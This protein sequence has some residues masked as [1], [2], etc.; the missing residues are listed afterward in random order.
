[1]NELKK[2]LD[3]KNVLGEFISIKPYVLM[4]L[5]VFWFYIYLL[6]NLLI[7]SNFYLLL[8]ILMTSFIYLILIIFT[9]I[10][11]YLDKDLG[12]SDKNKIKTILYNPLFLISYVYC[13]L[14]AA[15][16]DVNWERI[17]HKGNDKLN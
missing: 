2:H 6:I 12:I 13:I 9:D 14:K 4:L 15:F 16:S 3:N 17:E 11:V 5:G 10:L 8:I 7:N 1:M